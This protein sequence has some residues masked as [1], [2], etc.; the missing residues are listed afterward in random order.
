MKINEIIKNTQHPSLSESVNQALTEHLSKQVPLYDSIFR[1]QSDSYFETFRLAKQRR[2]DGKLPELDWESEELLRTDIGESVNLR[3][4]G[5]VWLDVPYMIEAVAGPEKCWPGHK[6]VGTKPGTGKNKG[7]RVN[8]CEK[9]SETKGLKKRVRVVKTGETG[10]IGEVRHGKYKGAPKEFT[11]DLDSGGSIRAQAAELRLIKEQGM[12]EDYR[13]LLPNLDE[14][15]GLL[16]QFTDGDQVRL[17]E[18]YAG[19]ST[20]VF[21]LKNWDGEVGWAMDQQG[22]GWRVDAR[23]IELVDDQ[24]DDDDW[25]DEND[26]PWDYSQ[27][28]EAEYQGKNVELGKPKRGGDKKFYVYVRDP[29]SKNIRKVSFGAKSG[30]GNLAVKLKDPKA[31]KAFADRHNCE[32]KND[33]TKPGYWACRLPRYAKSLGLSGGGTWW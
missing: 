12:A 26:S 30:G 28:K 13:E 18:P 27:I 10:T 29:Q 20:E 5:K 22:R 11:V 32:Q 3:G 6:K 8:D 25:D 19:G 23:Q 1:Y 33:K 4:I 14:S 17:T 24:D 16:E 15:C 9:I 31:R 7:K 2:A 21:T